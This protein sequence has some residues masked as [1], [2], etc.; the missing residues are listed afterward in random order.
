[1]DSIRSNKYA[2]F[3]N[4]KEKSWKYT[5]VGKHNVH[6]FDSIC[7]FIELIGDFQVL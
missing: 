5:K 6:E 4:F 1:M 7:I 2:W 3:K